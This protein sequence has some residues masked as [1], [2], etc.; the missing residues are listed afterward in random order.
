MTSP[1]SMT[2]VGLGATAAGGITD[3]IGKLFTG[4][5]TDQSYQ[6]QAAVARINSN[7]DLQNADYARQQ[8]EIQSSQYGLKEAATIGA[9][10]TAQG[11]SGLDVNSGS[12]VAVRTSQRAIGS[13]DTAQIRANAAKVAYDYDVRSTMDLNQ[14]TLDTMAGDNAKTASRIGAASSI[15]GTVGSVATKWN[16]A[17][18]AGVYGGSSSGGNYLGTPGSLNTGGLY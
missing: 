8:G 13:L 1:I 4:D 9:Q 6:Y 18:T 2:S 5:A 3:A 15:L 7:I 12:A 10:R 14:A 17:S 16:T 11:A